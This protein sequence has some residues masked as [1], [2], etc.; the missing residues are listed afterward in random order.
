MAIKY[1]VDE[2]NKTVRAEFNNCQFDA[3]NKIKK[4]LLRCQTEVYLDWEFNSKF[5]MARTYSATVKCH[6]SDVFA[7]E[8]GKRLAKEKLKNNY[9]KAV[10]KRLYKFINELYTIQ[11]EVYDG[12]FEEE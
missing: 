8:T 3:I 4:S 12:L 6:D 10:N 7:I 5:K 11:D 9:M 2:K 1:I